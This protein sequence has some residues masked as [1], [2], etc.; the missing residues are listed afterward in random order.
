MGTI[1]LGLFLM[2]CGIFLLW[3][4]DL[5]WELTERWKTSDSDGPSNLYLV[6]TRIGGGICILVGATG[7][8]LLFCV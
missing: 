4:P 8:I 3:K 7:L 1:L 2:I 5:V 6:S